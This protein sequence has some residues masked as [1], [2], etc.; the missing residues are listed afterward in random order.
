MIHYRSV[1]VMIDAPDLAEVTI[2][3]I[4]RYHGVLESII[5]DQGLL[6]ILKFWFSL[7]Y[8]LKIK[9]KPSTTFHLQT[10]SQIKRQNNTIEP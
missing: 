7:C 3:M 9:K 4:V 6:F 2:N 8:F 10:N 1:K 5:I